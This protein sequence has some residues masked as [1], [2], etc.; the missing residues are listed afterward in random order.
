MHLEFEFNQQD[1]I[2]IIKANI[3][4][5]GIIDNGKIKMSVD[6][7][8]NRLVFTHPGNENKKHILEQ[9]HEMYHET[10]E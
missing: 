9:H 7:E 10:G 3:Q 4:S 5:N 8:A 2:A 6:T 1:F